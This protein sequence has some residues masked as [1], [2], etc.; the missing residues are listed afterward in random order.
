V[1]GAEDRR[2]SSIRH[3]LAAAARVYD[4]RHSLI[5][6][7]AETTGLS[8]EGVELGFGYLERS[9][10]DADLGTLLAGASEAAHVHVILSANVFVAPLRALALAVAAAPKVTVRPSPRDPWLTRAL[11]GELENPCVRI[12]DERSAGALDADSFHVYGRDETIA[13]V[14]ASARRGAAI[15]G[16]GAGLGVVVLTQ[17]AQ[18]DDAAMRIALDVVAF[19]QRGCLSPRVVLVEGNLAQG[20]RVAEALH[21]ELAGLANLVPRGR[22]DPNE[23]EQAR[24]WTDTVSFAGRTW[25]GSDHVVGLG[26]EGEPLMLPPVGRHVH[27]A[28][29]RSLENARSLLDPTAR[30]IVAVGTDDPERVR[31]CVPGH[32]RLSPLGAMQRP[33]LDGPVDRRPV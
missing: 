9:A 15:C 2:V 27:V 19:D 33:P 4:G 32:A 8:P 26:P 25:Q 21:R 11:V 13:L 14:R 7:I 6:P 12:V 30:F 22:L 28:N 31:H 10:S 1:N 24:R 5:G 29:A 18:I 3:L 17:A 16:H 20:T 23:R